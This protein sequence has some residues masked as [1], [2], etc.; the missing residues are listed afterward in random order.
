MKRNYFESPSTAEDDLHLTEQQ[1]AALFDKIDP[2]DLCLPPVKKKSRKRQNS[3]ATYK[4][5]VEDAI[6]S[7]KQM[8]KERMKFVIPRFQ[9]TRTVSVVEGQQTG[10]KIIFCDCPFFAQYGLAC[11]H[12]YK[13]IS[14]HPRVEDALPR[15]LIAFI[16]YYGRNAEMS[17]KFV[18]LCESS[19][20]RGVTLSAADW[21][22]ISEEYAVGD[23]SKMPLEYFSCSLG[24][25][26]LCEPNYWQDIGD[27][28]VARCGCD[29]SVLGC[30]KPTSTNETSLTSGGLSMPKSKNNVRVAPIGLEQVVE[31]SSN[32]KVPTQLYDSEGDDD[33]VFDSTQNDDVMVGDDDDSDDGIVKGGSGNLYCDYLPVYGTITKLCKG[34]GNEGE[35]IL[36]NG[37]R[38]IRQQLLEA[39]AREDRRTTNEMPHVLKQKGK[40]TRKCKPGSPNKSRGT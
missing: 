2:D 21:S 29:T 37:L 11:R 4:K 31:C 14:R 27:R 17:Q 40:A 7:Y 23:G 12:I 22:R 5:D 10:E 24:K 20:K 36:Q 30:A 26:R 15:W 34:L 18:H 1:R 9:R 25:M 38:G 19:D 39:H 16:H 8:L 28:V 3:D 13:V 35:E 6:E 32:F 33:V